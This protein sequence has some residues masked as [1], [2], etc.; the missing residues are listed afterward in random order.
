MEAEVQDSLQGRQPA[1]SSKLLGRSSSLAVDAL[2]IATLIALCVALFYYLLTRFPYDGLYGQ[3]SYAYYYQAR[4]ILQD[5]TGQ[6]PQ[7]W[8]M[9]SGSQ[10]YHW[11]VG[12]HILIMLGQIVSGSVGGGR[13]ITLFMTAGATVILY[14]LVGELWPGA[15]RRARTLA[16][17]VAGAALPLIATYTRMGLSL[18]ADVPAIFWGLLGIYCSLR[19]WPVSIT[20]DQLPGTSSHSVI[21]NRWGWAFAGGLALGFAVLTRYGAIFFL[22]PVCVY[23]LLRRSM[24]QKRIDEPELRQQ[25]PPNSHRPALSGAN[26]SFWWLALG[27]ALGVLPQL[28]YLLAYNQITFVGNAAAGYSEWLGGWSPANYFA[29]T[30]SGPDGTSTFEHPMMLFYLIEP[31]YSSGAGFLSAF[32]LPALLMGAAVLVRSRLWPV[33]GLLATWWLLP[34]LF[35]SGTSYQAHRFALTYLPALLVL[36]GI[37]AATAIELG[38]RALRPVPTTE[39]AQQL[40]LSSS[41]VV[42]SALSVVVLAGLA[43]GVYQEQASV[44]SWMAIHESFKIDEQKVLSLARQAAGGYT[45]QDPPHI[46]SFGIGPALYH[47]T[48]WPIIE[49]FNS[50]EALI[51][52]FLDEPGPHLLIVPEQTLSTQW[53]GTPVADR[54]NWLKQTYPVTSHGLAGIYSVYTIGKRK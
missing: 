48:Q 53:A 26:G 39:Q 38:V 10:L 40:P 33:I 13:A 5:I 46:V 49:I 54:L 20:E 29:T 7:A 35:F 4:A 17:L 30:I 2:A 25:E 28:I 23:L 47:Y 14:L 44:R 31:L 1:K 50:D 22:A 3:D 52:R 18:M 19:A 36:L 21:R 27:F 34:V 37:G 11:P 51:M 12:Y 43:A 15:P 16:G 41:R 42:S 6:P 9:F 32:Y 24:N 45:D 8:S